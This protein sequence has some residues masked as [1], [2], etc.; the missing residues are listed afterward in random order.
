MSDVQSQADSDAYDELPES[1]DKAQVAEAAREIIKCL[2]DERECTYKRLA[3]QVSYFADS[4]INDDAIRIF[5]AHKDASRVN[6]NNLTLKALYNYI[7]KYYH[8]FPGRTKALFFELREKLGLLTGP[9]VDDAIV[10]IGTHR[11]VHAGKKDIQRLA[12]K[13]EGRYIVVRRSTVNAK[14]IKS[15]LTVTRMRSSDHANPN[16]YLRTEH[17]HFDRSQTPRIAEGFAFPVAGNIYMAMR[18]E[19]QEGMEIIVVRD[20][21]QK[22]PNFFMGFMLGL[23]GNRNIFNSSVLL[24]RLTP[25]SARVWDHVGNRFARE[26]PLLAGLGSTFLHRLDQVIDELRSKLLTRFENDDNEV[27]R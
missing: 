18:I 12:A 24:E 20:P 11:W 9:A 6:A 23:N 4:D 27:E 5:L 22:Q 10:A 17:V 16:H 21:M 26:N 7:V 3:R 25:Q 14:Y 2:I 19:G 13:L 1:V 8:H 15:V